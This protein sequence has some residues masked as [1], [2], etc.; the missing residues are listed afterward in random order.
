MG[1]DPSFKHPTCLATLKSSD[2]RKQSICGWQYIY[3][4]I[5][6]ELSFSRYLFIASIYFEMVIINYSPM[7]S[8]HQVVSSWLRKWININNNSRIGESDTNNKNIQPGYRNGIWYKKKC[9]ADNENWKKT[10]NRKNRIDKLRKNQKTWRKGKLQVLGNI[11][12]RPP[13]NKWKWKEKTTVPQTNEKR[14]KTKLC[15]GNLIKD[16]HLGT[17]LWKILGTILKMDKGGT[18]TKSSKDKKMMMYQALHLKDNIDCMSQ[19]NKEEDLPVLMIEW[20]H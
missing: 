2:R 14:F 18:N 13:S 5:I 8:V 10:N 17:P 20:I 6:T 12:S 9:Y 4:Y 7:W 11:E 1:F 3:I 15:R 19:G 16:K